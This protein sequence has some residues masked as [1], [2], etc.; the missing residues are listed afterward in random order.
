MGGVLCS[1]LSKRAL[2]FYLGGQVHCAYISSSAS[3]P[4]KGRTRNRIFARLSSQPW[5][6]SGVH[7][8]VLAQEMGCPCLDPTKSMRLSFPSL[9]LSCHLVWRNDMFARSYTL[10]L[11]PLSFIL[12]QL[13]WCIF[14]NRTDAALSFV[15]G[16][17]FTE[18]PWPQNFH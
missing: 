4:I 18:H 12:F 11:Y 6:T 3:P 16:Y 8:M 2:R 14:S 5:I 9:S 17:N 15:A 7:H 1:H 10:I 13:Y